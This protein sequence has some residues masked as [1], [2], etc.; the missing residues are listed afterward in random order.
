MDS[1]YH[2]T[3][4]LQQEVQDNFVLLEKSSGQTAEKLE[5]IIQARIDQITS[6]CEILARL[7]DKELA[8]RKAN[9]KLKV[10]QLKYDC[11]HLQAA[12]RNLQ[13]R[14]FTREREVQEREDLLARRFTTNDQ[15]TSIAMDY[16]MQM[17][18]SVHNAHRGVD[19]LIDS[20]GNILS[21][22]RGQRHT[23]KGVHKKILDVAN[24]LGLSN[25]V[26]RLIERRTVQD[27]FILYGGMV[28][29]LVI[30]F[31]LYKYLA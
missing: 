31:M 14:R 2:Q 6:N 29:T 22:L 30:M 8:P 27:K 21:N 13:H 18:N 5:Q 3:N 20:G 11:Q 23:L 26:M 15:V 12:L 9:A 17:N 7:A 19:D 1:M 28:V 25:T 10:D 4:K 16:E 24:T